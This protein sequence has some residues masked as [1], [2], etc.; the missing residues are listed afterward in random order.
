M[1]EFGEQFKKVITIK[2]NNKSP[3]C[4]YGLNQKI[5]QTLSFEQ[6]KQYLIDKGYAA[7]IDYNDKEGI[8]KFAKEVMDV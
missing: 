8:V 3:D 2:E 6:A 5:T 4:I 1:V 7:Y